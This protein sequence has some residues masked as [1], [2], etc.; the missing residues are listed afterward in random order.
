MEYLR[1]ICSMRGNG[2]F[3]LKIAEEKAVY[4]ILECLVKVQKSCDIKKIVYQLLNI[5]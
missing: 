4:C 3:V 2:F 1:N 5:F